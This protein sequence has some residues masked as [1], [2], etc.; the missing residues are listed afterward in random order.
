[1]HVYARSRAVGRRNWYDC[2]IQDK[3]ENFEGFLQASSEDRSHF[4]HG[5]TA[6]GRTN[7]NA[8]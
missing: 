3:I 7:A 5:K 4:G 2:G 8:S 1:M 6:E